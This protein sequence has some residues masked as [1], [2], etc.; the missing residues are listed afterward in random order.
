MSVI[1]G[2][3]PLTAFLDDPD[4]LPDDFMV[5][6]VFVGR[7]DHENALTA[8]CEQLHV[9]RSCWSGLQ[10]GDG[11]TIKREA[12]TAFLIPIGGQLVDHINK[13]SVTAFLDALTCFL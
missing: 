12:L 13:H 9:M 8:I 4:G 10:I 3:Y 11:Q 1:I 6:W 2:C 5:W 7:P